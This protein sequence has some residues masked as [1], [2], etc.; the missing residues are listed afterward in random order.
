MANLFSYAKLENIFSRLKVALQRWVRT[1]NFQ[2]WTYV[3]FANNEMFFWLQ[4]HFY[5]FSVEVAREAT[6]E[7]LCL[8]SLLKWLMS[9]HFQRS[10]WMYVQLCLKKKR[11]IWPSCC[12][13]FQ[14]EYIDF[15]A[16]QL[17]FLFFVFTSEH[18]FI[19][20]AAIFETYT[21]SFVEF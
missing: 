19:W 6:F 8:N 1:W 14:L 3:N 16:C 2:T 7:I 20:R 21:R 17:F 12:T 10:L 15:V 13:R 9:L 18:I 5:S 4:I 11:S